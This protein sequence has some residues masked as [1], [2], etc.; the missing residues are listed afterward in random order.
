MITVK[1]NRM[2]KNRLLYIA[3]VFSLLLAGC[4][5]D[6]MD[7]AETPGTSPAVLSLQVAADGYR[8]PAETRAG[9]TGIET[10]FTN[11][12]KL[13]LIISHPDNTMKHAVYTYNGSSWTSSTPAYYDPKDTYAAYYPYKES[14]HGKTLD[15]IKSAFTPLTDQSDYATGYAASDLMTC[16][17]TTLNTTDKTLSIT[18][19][20]AFSMLRMPVTVPVKIKCADNNTYEYSVSATDIVFHI[21]DTPY[22]AWV[23]GDGYA[24][25]IVSN[26]SSS[27]AVKS[28]Y[29][30]GKRAETGCTISSFASGWYYTVTPPHA[31]LGEYQLS[32]ARVGDFYCKSSDGQSG[33]VF[34]REAS[35]LPESLKNSCLGIVLKVGKDNADDW[36]DN[37]QYKLKGTTT[38]MSTIHGYVLALYDANSGN[39]CKWG[40]NGTQVDHTDMN[41]EQNTGFYG[42]K[43]TQAI[44]SF[45]N[46]KSGTLSSAFPATYYATTD[47]ETRENSKYA[48]PANS[49]G[50][51]LL[52]AGQCKYWLNNKETLLA[53]VRKATGDSGYSWKRLYWSSSESDSQD[54]MNYVWGATFYQNSVYHFLKRF[55]SYVR[56]CLAF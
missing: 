44:I 40:S 27:I 50:W 3:A 45:N 18:L 47:Y 36:Q 10:T 13:G 26:S 53:S 31:D 17:N 39:I 48:S 25:L 6:E 49:S 54:P 43:N 46:S 5:Q 2:M 14:L 1:M 16:E 15:A 56:S 52:S 12:D 33:F 9:D 35:S 30:V 21:G 7:R 37:C 4:S 20:H 32:D 55:N 24:R 42:Y 34:P 11:G 28:R 23:D 22:R 41:R 19:T 8:S 29:T 38:A 51:F